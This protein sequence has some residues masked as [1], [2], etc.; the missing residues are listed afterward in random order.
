MQFDPTT[1]DL[2]TDDGRFLKRL[3]CPEKMRW[4]QLSPGTSPAARSCH[5]CEHLVHDTAMMT[6]QD[7]VALLQ[8]KPNACL[9]VSSAQDNCSLRPSSK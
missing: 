6:D 5:A 2:F 8:A 1:G 7:L 4:E 9:K 3:H